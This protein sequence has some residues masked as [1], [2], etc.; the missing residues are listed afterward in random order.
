MV[1]ATARGP[2]VSLCFSG[3]AT[4]PVAGAHE[5]QWPDAEVLGGS[6]EKICGNMH[7]CAIFG[8]DVLIKDGDLH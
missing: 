5:V 2:M 3:Q 1:E 4:I 6:D 8:Q 7:T